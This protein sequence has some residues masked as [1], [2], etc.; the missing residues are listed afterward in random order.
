MR[1]AMLIIGLWHLAAGC[2]GA[3]SSSGTTPTGGGATLHS[4]ELNRIMKLEVNQPFS[5]MQFM[6]F[7][8]EGGEIDFAALA[9]DIGREAG[10]ATVKGDPFNRAGAYSDHVDATHLADLTALA[11]DTG[12][13]KTATLRNVARTGPYMHDGVY[14][15]LWDVV[16][17][18]NFGGQTGA[19]S[20][21][22]DV[23]IVPLLLDA[24]ETSDLVEFLG[25]LS[26]GEPLPTTDFPEGL[27]A[28]PTLP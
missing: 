5:A 17:H 19:Y 12:A 27:V 18:Y 8:A 10:I 14:T 26:D 7:H 4:P 3:K 22:K 15:T 11:T 9:T 6:V 1:T 23:A 25:S 24:R 28:A 20:G 16:N 13:F 21:T 2:G